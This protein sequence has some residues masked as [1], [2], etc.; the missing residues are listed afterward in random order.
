MWLFRLGRSRPRKSITEGNSGTTSAQFN[1]VRT[2][3]RDKTASATWQ[4]V[5]SGTNPIDLDD[6]NG[7]V[8]PSGTVNFAVN[9][10]VATVTVP[11]TGDL[12]LEADETFDLIVTSTNAGPITGGPRTITIVNDD[13]ALP[14]NV[15]SVVIND[16]AAQRSAV[17]KIDVVF[18]SLVNAPASAFSLTNLGTYAS[19]ASDPVTGLSVSA[20]NTGPVTIVTI[21]LLSGQSLP[22]ANYR[23]DI[24]AAQITAAGGG[25]AMASNYAFGD[26]P[27]DNFFRRYGD[28]DGDGF[29]DFDDFS[30]HFLPAFGT[31]LAVTVHRSAANSISTVTMMSISTTSPLVSCPDFGTER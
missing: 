8:Y 29:V 15:A 10:G 12:L 9:D 30:G 21:S 24:N 2:G 13:T 5:P 20:D 27:L 11:I 14:P 1:I 25:P 3:N 31:S 28:G 6:I 16:G 17:T 4:V 23:L 22:D 19:P 26:D 18:D 7:S